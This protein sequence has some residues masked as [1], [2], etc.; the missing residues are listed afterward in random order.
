L[1]AIAGQL[2]AN[3]FSDRVKVVPAAAGVSKT[4]GYLVDA[5][6]SSTI[7]ESGDFAV[8]VVDLFQTVKGPIDILKIDIEGGEY[9]LLAD[10]RFGSLGA[11]TVVVEWHKRAN[12]PDGRKWCEDRLRR[13]GYRTSIGFEDLPLAGLIW[14][15]RTDQSPAGQA[16]QV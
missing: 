2:A 16:Q 13:F 7:A 14:G 5:G 11:R 12:C 9:K 1:K 15:F 8:Q 4:A 10:E 3:R 6:S